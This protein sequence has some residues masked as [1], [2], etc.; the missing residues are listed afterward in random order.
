MALIICQAIAYI[1]ILSAGYNLWGIDPRILVNLSLGQNT[2]LVGLFIVLQL[3]GLIGA[4]LIIQEKRLGYVLSIAHHILL[5]PALV[6][7][8]W[9]LVM[10][11]D[12]RIN[13]T[14]LFMSKPDVKDVGLYWSLGWGT[15]FQQV[16]RDVPTGSTYLGVNL[17]ALA[18]AYALWSVLREADAALAQ[19]EMKM[20][21]RGRQSRRHPMALPAPER[22][23]QKQRMRPQRGGVRQPRQSSRPW[24]Y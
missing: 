17:F 10:L 1:Q 24:D 20:R 12:D 2:I 16:T 6:I 4:I 13:I 8:S 18:C 23:P 15:V 5:L 21:R 11:M 22:N 7:T 9:G 19:R 3:F 14:L